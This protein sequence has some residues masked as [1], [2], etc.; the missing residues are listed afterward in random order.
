MWE[1]LVLEEV[2][3]HTVFIG[4]VDCLFDNLFRLGFTPYNVVLDYVC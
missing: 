3:G 4:N 2:C 1:M